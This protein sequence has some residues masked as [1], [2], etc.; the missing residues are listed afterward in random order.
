[1]ILFQPFGAPALR[2]PSGR[3]FSVVSFNKSRLCS[4]MFWVL[5]V[6]VRGFVFR[7]FEAARF[8]VSRF[9]VRGFVIRDFMC[10]VFNVDRSGSYD[11]SSSRLCDNNNYVLIHSIILD[12][13][14]REKFKW[15]VL[16]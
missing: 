12:T 15:L 16:I 6:C 13:V 3:R 11:T 7:Y 2:G 8:C 10:A 4:S 5:R 14:S 1:M 9:C